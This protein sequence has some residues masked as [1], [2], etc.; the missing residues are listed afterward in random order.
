MSLEDILAKMTTI[1]ANLILPAMAGRGFIE[2]G[3]RADLVVFDPRKINGKA[4]V[5]NPNQFSE[6][7]SMVFVNGK[8]A[9]ENGILLQSA[10][11]AIKYNGRG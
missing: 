5:E 10:G 2:N 3:S 1:P 9:Y 8:P 4:S 6:G 11:V 7:I